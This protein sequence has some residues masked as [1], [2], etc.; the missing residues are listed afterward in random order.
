MS[1]G[2]EKSHRYGV[3]KKSD[4]K[5]ILKEKKNVN[6]ATKQPKAPKPAGA[7]GN[8]SASD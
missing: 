6:K 3:E 4:L 1:R 5:G 2:L 8:G 7:L